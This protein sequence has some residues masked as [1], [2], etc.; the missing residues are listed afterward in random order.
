MGRTERRGRRSSTE[1][2]IDILQGGSR[3]RGEAERVIA[4]AAL[5]V[6]N[7]SIRM[8]RC[9]AWSKGVVVV[10]LMRVVLGSIVSRRSVERSHLIAGGAHGHNRRE[11]AGVVRFYDDQEDA[12]PELSQAH[13][14]LVRLFLRGRA[15]GVTHSL[16]ESS[17]K[18]TAFV[19]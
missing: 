4:I 16:S 2:S 19:L 17:R 7:R 18:A 10:I 9:L 3:R 1:F 11:F 15:A 6:R 13:E 5:P 14:T 12:R 8:R